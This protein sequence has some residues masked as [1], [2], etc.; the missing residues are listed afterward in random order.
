M[1]KIVFILFL[2]VSHFNLYCE[3]NEENKSTLETVCEI[4]DAQN[5]SIL[6]VISTVKKMKE[7]ID[8]IMSENVNLNAYIDDLTKNVIE[9][10][11]NNEQMSVLVKNLTKDIAEY[12]ERKNRAN[13]FVQ[14]MI[15]TT[16]IPLIC[17]GG[18]AY[19]K[20]EKTLGKTL[21]G[22]G[23]ILLI[24]GELTWNGGKFILKI[25]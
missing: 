23:G 18:Y 4:F 21:I 7:K 19:I 9:S 24:G 2:I 13:K 11:K 10:N 22:C 20:D 8:L 5:E 25:W 17:G 15:P 14:I 6:N 16:T 12:E 3:S 1:K